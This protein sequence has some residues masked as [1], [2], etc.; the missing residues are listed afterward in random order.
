MRNAK[1]V[2]SFFEEINVTEI[3]KKKKNLKILFAYLQQGEITFLPF[4]ETRPHTQENCRA[5]GLKWHQLAA[6]KSTEK[7]EVHLTALFHS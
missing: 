4:V 7:D 1:E 5:N 3:K 2:K 6:L